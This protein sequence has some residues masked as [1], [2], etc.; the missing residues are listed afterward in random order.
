MQAIPTQLPVSFIDQAHNA[1]RTSWSTQAV[2]QWRQF[3]FTHR[4]A[5]AIREVC[6][7]RQLRRCALSSPRRLLSPQFSRPRTTAPRTGGCENPDK[8]KKM[9]SFQELKF[10]YRSQWTAVLTSTRSTRYGK[11][12]PPNQLCL[13]TFR[14]DKRVGACSETTVL[15]STCVRGLSGQDLY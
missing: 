4:V 11:Q 1:Q 15:S 6:S 12:G 2:R 13:F 8:R 14:G 3:L 10:K 7:F 5:S 9:C